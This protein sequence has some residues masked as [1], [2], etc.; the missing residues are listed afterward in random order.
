MGGENSTIDTNNRRNL[1]FVISVLLVCIPW[2][3]GRAGDDFIGT[4]RPDAVI[5]LHWVRGE[6]LGHRGVDER[7][8][9]PAGDP[10]GVDNTGGVFV[11]CPKEFLPRR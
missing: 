5:F 2:L 1:Y 9:S 10:E 3:Q 6:N 4:Y 11:V 7:L 8:G